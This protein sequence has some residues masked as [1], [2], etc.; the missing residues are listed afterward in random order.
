MKM[1]KLLILS[2]ALITALSF[3]ACKD[4]DKKKGSNNAIN[5]ST[6]DEY[7]SHI[8]FQDYEGYEFRIL[9]RK[10]QL[11]SQYVEEE[12][13]DIVNDAVYKRNEE[14]KALFNIEITAT[15]SNNSDTGTA[16]LNGILAGDDQ[17]DLLFPH[18][19]SAFTYAIQNAAV[20]YNDVETIHLDKPW[21]AQDI[22][23]SA[24]VN[25]YLYVL[26]GDISTMR[27][28]QS[29]AMF[30][31][32]DLFDE[33]GL[34]Y[35][36]QL[37]LDGEWTFD[38]FS[39][40]VKKGSKD[41]NG[42]GVM[43]QDVDRFG[44]YTRDWQGP[45]AILY[46]AGQR[47]YD[48]NARGIP[49]LTL[50][51]QKTTDVF[52][53]FFDLTNSDHAFLALNGRRDVKSG[54][55]PFKEGRALFHDGGLGNAQSMRNMEDD[56]GI[57]PMPKFTAED[58]YAAIV[59]GYSSLMVMPITVGDVNRTGAITEA[60]C[61]I[62]SREVIPAFYNVSLQTKFARDAESEKMIDIIKDAAIYD[63]GYIAGGTFQSCGYDLA[64]STNQNF[65]S[66]YAA[67]ESAAQ[68]AL[69]EFNRA[70]GKLG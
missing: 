6:D 1:K 12:T 63:L 14:V 26:D 55:N 62:G 39:K 38:A 16:A 58:K 34:E 20:N 44:Y 33:L 31:N 30:F 15:E 54:T 65:A 29:A 53:E 61:A 2:L 24:D 11:K 50:N 8:D 19:R 52:E 22:V 4:D 69:Q 9:T 47:I 49:T 68:T 36:Y 10:N 57:I 45:I 25:G 59:N 35:P 64:H 27:L 51:S 42:D 21:W 41:L 40:L 18:S 48:K 67:S 46:T 66:Y 23:N 70:Y 37:V 43:H 32:K 13:G 3:T 7:T 17:Y 28:A 56:F 5:I 60:L